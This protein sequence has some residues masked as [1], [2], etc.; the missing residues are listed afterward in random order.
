MTAT[1]I[2]VLLPL[3][4]ALLIG[5]LIDA[6]RAEER[7]GPYA[8]E[9]GASVG[10]LFVDDSLAGADGPTIEPMFDARIGGPFPAKGFTWFA[11]LSGYEVDTE[12]FR[13]KASAFTGRAGLEVPFLPE[14]R[15]PFFVSLSAGL[16]K[17]T[18]DNATDFDS[19]IVS[20]GIG[21]WIWLSGNN[22][23]RWEY[24][25]DHTL[26]DAGLMGSD[27]TQPQFLIGYHWRRGVRPV[28]AAKKTPAAEPPPP[29]V[30]PVAPA[31]PPPDSDSDGVP[32]DDD[33]C[34]DTMPGIEAGATGCPRDDDLDG[35]YDG[36]GMDKCPNTPRGAV[37]DTHGCPVD[38]DLDGV[39]DGID[40]CPGTPIGVEVDREGCPEG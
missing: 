30:V 20:A 31:P 4:A 25:A 39:Y 21:Q 35:V 28:S 10:L 15:S 9:A 37:V 2:R 14:R 11:D 29:A 18:F 33:L 27:V 1:R 22:W 17:I 7:D 24:R 34:P 36:L 8:L 16:T 32:D 3:L 19:A 13:G 23:L 40:R 38:S 26:A 6:V 5:G 12:T